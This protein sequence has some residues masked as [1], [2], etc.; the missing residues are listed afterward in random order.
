MS[1]AGAA[2]ATGAVT[3]VTVRGFGDQFNELLLE[4]RPIASGN[5][6]NFDFSTMSANYIGEIDIHKTPDFA[7]SSGAVGATI[8]V[9]FPNPFDNPGFH[10]Q[11]SV[12]GT[13]YQSDGG[14]R[15]AF[16][17]L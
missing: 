14:I 2:T 12:S 17:A 5:G 3:G 8:N 9:K 6:Q 15:P 1:S 4:G 16:G 13:D 11:A 7:L 10:L